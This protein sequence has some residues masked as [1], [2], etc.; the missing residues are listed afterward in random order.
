MTAPVAAADRAIRL[1]VVP[2]ASYPTVLQGQL[3]ASYPQQ[4][5]EISVS[6]Q[7][8]GGETV[9][10]GALRF[11]GVFE[12]SQAQVV[13]VQEGVNGLAFAGAEASAALIR[14]MVQ[15]ATN[16]GARVF[17]GSMLPTLP[18]RQRSQNPALLVAYN[19]ALRAMC[20][21]ERVT[22]VDLY[23]GILAQAEQ[24][25][26]IDG[27]HPTEAGYRRIAELFFTA[28]KSELEER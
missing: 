19:D 13:L 4:A 7:G 24:L 8:R 26:G 28:I 16:G 25:I 11:E 12:A 22:Y 6:N 3:Q 10:D 18:N 15:R 1:V 17:V 27:L 14:Q 9:F 20:T 23:N 21:L 2:S 5:S